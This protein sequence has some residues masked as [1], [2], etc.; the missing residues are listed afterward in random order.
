[1]GQIGP[2]GFF[3]FMA[4][5]F[6]ILAAYTAYRMTRRQAPEVQEAAST[7]TMP[8]ISI[9]AVE[10][11]LGKT[12]TRCIAQRLRCW[13]QTLPTVVGRRSASAPA[14]GL[15]HLRCTSFGK[16]VS[17]RKGGLE[18][19]VND[20]R[21]GVSCLIQVDVLDFWLGEVGPDGWYAG[22]AADL[23]TRCYEEFRDLWLRSRP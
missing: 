1:M 23:D 9:V 13:H 3:L 7:P 20:Q 16:P 2:D 10:A 12:S 6:A 5:L 21:T 22:D 18:R 14:Q 15:R 4:L 8:T 17:L 11:A 19:P